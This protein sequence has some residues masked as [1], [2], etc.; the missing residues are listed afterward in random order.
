MKTN[1]CALTFL[2][3]AFSLTLSSAGFADPRPWS[4]VDFNQHYQLHQ[5]TQNA[6]MDPPTRGP[7]SVTEPKAGTV[8][9]EK[10]PSPSVNRPGVDP[11]HRTVRTGWT[12]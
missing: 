2:S 1:L 12:F 11:Y 10:N 9:E 8:T 4:Q 5:E 7:A 3:L 6:K